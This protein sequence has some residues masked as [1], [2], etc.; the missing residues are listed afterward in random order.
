V[1]WRLVAQGRVSAA[2]VVVVF[3]IADDQLGG[4]GQRPEAAGVEAFAQPG[5]AGVRP[6]MVFGGLRPVTAPQP[7]EW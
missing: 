5:V 1:G 4:V 7:A 6:C 2:V 3:P